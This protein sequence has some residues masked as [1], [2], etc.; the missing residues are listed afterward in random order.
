M[1]PILSVFLLSILIL[2]SCQKEGDKT[3][4]DPETKSI[5]NLHQSYI[6]GWLEMNESKVVDLFEENSRIQPSSLNPVSGKENIREFWFPKDGSQTIIHA[7][8]TE[9]LGVAIKDTLG[10]STHKTLLDWSY[11]KDTI[12]MGMIQEGITTTLYRKQED[13]SWKIWRQMWTDIKATPK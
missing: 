8:E 1:K 10:I 11:E 9:L 6:D 12:K 2:F 4:L 13:S 3:N 5:L 7:F